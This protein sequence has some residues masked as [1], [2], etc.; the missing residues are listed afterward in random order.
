MYVQCTWG[1]I[2]IIGLYLY[3]T[4]LSIYYMVT[5][6]GGPRDARIAAYKT[7][8]K[9]E[10]KSPSKKKEKEEKVEEK[11]YNYED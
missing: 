3:N 10:V 8:Q 6:K 7:A 1:C 2:L 11:T 9:E 5:I 4:I